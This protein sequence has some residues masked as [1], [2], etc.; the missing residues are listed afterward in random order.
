[1]P[2][3]QSS[4]RLLCEV[5]NGQSK[6]HLHSTCL[7]WPNLKSSCQVQK[8]CYSPHVRSASSHWRQDRDPVEVAHCPSAICVQRHLPSENAADR[9]EGTGLSVLQSETLAFTAT[10]EQATKT[11]IKSASVHRSAD[12]LQRQLSIPCFTVAPLTRATKNWR[13][14]DALRLRQREDGWA[15]AIISIGSCCIFLTAYI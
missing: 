7:P 6:R 15:G 8:A 13:Q 10:P 3:A 5:H 9:R 1:M 4:R 14:M 11:Q 2:A 12:A